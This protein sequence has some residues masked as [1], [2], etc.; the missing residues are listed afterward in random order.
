VYTACVSRALRR[1]AIALAAVPLIALVALGS[2][3][4]AQPTSFSVTRTRT[5]AA[6]PDRVM[7]QLSDLRAFEA[8]HP[9]PPEPGATPSVT[10]ST[11]STGLGAWMERRDPY[12]GART[13]IRSLDADHVVM[14][15]ETLGSLGG[16]VSTQSFTL[17]G[18]SAGTEVSWSFGAGLHGLARLI[19]PFVRVDQRL[20]MEMDA[21]LDRLERAVVR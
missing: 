16:N 21:G 8:W 18:T 11:V 20:P 13:T 12:G 1:I 14:T 9:W 4:V 7:A 17:R 10:F 19:W 5:I 15:N 6:P 2:L 3:Y